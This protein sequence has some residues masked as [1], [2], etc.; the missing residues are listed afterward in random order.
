MVARR[1]QG[2]RSWPMEPIAFLALYAGLIIG[3][4]WFLRSRTRMPTPPVAGGIPPSPEALAWLRAGRDGVLTLAIYD[5]ACI[6]AVR[7]AGQAVFRQPAGEPAT[8]LAAE[9]LAVLPYRATTA[10]LAALADATPSLAGP[11]AAQ[12]RFWEERGV[13]TDPTQARLAGRGAWLLGSTVGGLGLWQVVTGGGLQ[14]FTII[15]GLF[16]MA[17]IA[18]TVPLPRLTAAGSHELLARQRAAG[19]NADLRE[20]VAVSGTAALTQTA[21]AEL[22]VLYPPETG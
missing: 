8:G 15:M 11:I 2:A 9:L 3:G 21:L 17:A 14:G 4:I 19:A 1:R 22:A 7:L 13:A 12:A 6:G 10:E 18:L 20:V 16:G 5:L